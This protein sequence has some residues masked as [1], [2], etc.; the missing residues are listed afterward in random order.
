MNVFSFFILNIV[1]NSVLAF[2]T[3][4]FLI[5]MLIAIFRIKQGRCAAYLR[6][7]PIL[8]LPLDPFLYDFSN[9]SFLKGINPL[10]CEENSRTLSAMCGYTNEGVFV[11]PSSVQIYMSVP[12]NFTFTL[13]DLVGHIIPTTL[14]HTFATS[15]CCLTLCVVAIR[16]KNLLSS[17]SQLDALNFNSSFG[18]RI[19]NHKLSQFLKKYPL[20]IITSKKFKGSPFVV[21][22]VS[23]TIYIP[24]SLSKML[25]QNEYDAVLAHEIEHIR[26]KDII[27]RCLLIIIGSL[28]WWVPT[29]WLRRRIEE[30]QEIGCDLHCARYGINSFDLISAI[31]KTQKISQQDI[32]D[33]AF[34]L[35]H[36]HPVQQRI[37]LLLNEPKAQKFIYAR[38][39]LIAFA[40]GVAF[41]GIFLGRFWIF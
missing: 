27:V 12:G 10:Y 9:W 15:F 40:V 28:F 23:P 41:Y 38:Y 30:G 26:H 25:S 8:K 33:L 39:V 2:F 17:K 11:I 5:E 6:L 21:G 37:Q 18:K 4:V 19:R 16:F 31:H 13:A 22:F 3:T 14:L 24:Q 7:I 1:L 29:K 36:R 35:T 32:P 20:K 34:C